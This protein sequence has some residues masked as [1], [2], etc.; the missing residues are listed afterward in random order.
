MSVGRKSDKETIRKVILAVGQSRAF[1]SNEIRDLDLA[2]HRAEAGEDF[3]GHF[4]YSSDPQEE[5]EQ[6]AEHES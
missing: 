2:I 3:N 5:A 4:V 1:W 6:L